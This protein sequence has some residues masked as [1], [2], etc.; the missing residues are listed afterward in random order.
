MANLEDLKPGTR[1]RVP[2]R[3]NAT[4]TIVGEVFTDNSATPPRPVVKIK[5]DGA[6]AGFNWLEQIEVIGAA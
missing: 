2:F 6:G 4:G 5:F 1:V 3:K